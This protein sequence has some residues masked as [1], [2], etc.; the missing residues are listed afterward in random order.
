PPR[1][2][3][4]RP[5]WHDPVRARDRPQAVEVAATDARALTRRPIPDSRGSSDLG[6]SLGRDPSAAREGAAGPTIGSPREGEVAAPVV[7]WRASRLQTLQSSTTE[8]PQ[9]ARDDLSSAAVSS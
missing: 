5:A 9:R 1:R 4:G 3:P 7:V 2:V 8:D 6:E